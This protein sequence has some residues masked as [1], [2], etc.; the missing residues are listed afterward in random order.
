M[1]DIPVPDLT[2]QDLVVLTRWMAEQGLFTADEVADAVEK[3]WKYAD[4]LELARQ[5]KD[6]PDD[7]E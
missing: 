7:D 4:L 6:L 2:H 3:P 5:G 1:N